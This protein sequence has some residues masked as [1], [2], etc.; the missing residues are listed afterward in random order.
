MLRN[1]TPAPDFTLPDAD[2]QPRGLADLRQGKPLLLAFFRFEECPTARRD[3]ARYVESYNRITGFGSDMAAISADTVEH[4]RHLVERLDA[5]FPILSDASFRVS[6]EY[7]VYRSDETEP[8]T[9]HGEP[10]VFILDVDGHIAYSQVQTG[11]KGSAS[12][13]ALAL[14]LFYMSQNDGRY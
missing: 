11:P 14:V 3:L 5:P 6:E 13:D 10:A 2:N 7:G 12:P 9:P 4:H 8:P 1:G